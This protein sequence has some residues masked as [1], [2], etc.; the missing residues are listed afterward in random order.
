MRHIRFRF[1]DKDLKKMIYRKPGYNDFSHPNIIPQQFTGFTDK[2]GIDIY[3]GDI[4]SDWTETDE[5]LLESNMQVFWNEPTGSWHLD[6][7]SKQDQTCSVDLWLELND[8][9]YA[10]TSNIFE[11]R[12]EKIKEKASTP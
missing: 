6:N 2:F 5:G 9:E 12:K 11:P 8:F 1:W 4:I 3:E 10:I 7:S